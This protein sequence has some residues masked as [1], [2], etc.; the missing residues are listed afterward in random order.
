MSR[1]RK[2]Q[3]KSRDGIRQ[4]ILFEGL[5]N[6]K[7]SLSDLDAVIELRDKFLILFEVKKSGFDIPRGQRTMLEAIVDA[8]DET[9]RIGMIVKADHNS[10]KDHILLRTCVV[11][12]VYYKGSWRPV[13]D[14]T[15]REFLDN[16][17][18]KNNIEL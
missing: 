2:H 1:T 14:I 8:W 6:N 16:F 7:V 18:K 11:M 15:V 3:I 13:G 9:G 5:Q 12:E 10:D 4:V 17:Y